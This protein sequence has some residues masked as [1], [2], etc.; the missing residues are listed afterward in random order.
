M[1]KVVLIGRLTRDVELK[2]AGEKGTAVATLTLAI[3]RRKQKDK[4]QEADF[5][6]VVLWGTLAENTSKFKHKGDQLAIVGRI[7]TRT[8]LA[9]D[10][11][12]KYVT[13]VVAE[14]ADFL[15]KNAGSSS[16]SGTTAPPP[17]NNQMDDFKP[18][19]DDDDDLPF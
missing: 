18:M 1:N 11:T 8:Y 10:G 13:E 4:D 16:A 7:S 3:N 2:Y 14:E 19:E 15:G 6:P 12:K 17:S 9:D 5:I